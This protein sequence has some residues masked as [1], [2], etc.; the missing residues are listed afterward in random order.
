VETDWEMVADQIRTRTRKGALVVLLTPVE[1]AAVQQGLLPVT[2]RIAADHPLVV[3]S[4]QDP[5]LQAMTRDRETV[6]DVYRAASAEADLLVRDG[7]GRAL[8]RSGA[9]VV[10]AGP[11]DLPRALADEYLSLKAAGKL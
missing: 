5:S 4:V 2:A 8:G 3:A 10:D 1:P 6:T 11:E 9:H 7:V